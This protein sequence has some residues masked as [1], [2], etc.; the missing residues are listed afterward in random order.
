MNY[1]NC[2]LRYSSRQRAYVL[3]KYARPNLER[4]EAHAALLRERVYFISPSDTYVVKDD[5]PTSWFDE[6]Y[7]I[8]G[9]VWKWGWNMPGSFGSQVDFSRGG[10][11]R[12]AMIAGIN[13]W[14][15]PIQRACWN[16]AWKS[17]PGR[18]FFGKCGASQVKRYCDDKMFPSFLELDD[19][20]NKDC[21]CFLD[22]WSAH[23]G[24]RADFKGLNN[25]QVAQWIQTE[26]AEGKPDALQAFNL[27]DAQNHSQWEGKRKELFLFIKEWDLQNRELQQLATDYGINLTYLAPFW[28]GTNPQEYIWAEVKRLYK[29]DT[30]NDTWEVKLER[31]WQ[32]IDDVFVKKCISRSI[33]FTFTEV[34]RLKKKREVAEPVPHVQA[35]DPAAHSDSEE[36]DD[37]MENDAD[38]DL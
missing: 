6:A 34:E 31:A 2:E 25:E 36:D 4:L 9:E 11:R 3:R 32:K 37:F 28:S 35:A 22:N 23:T 1:V 17:K 29:M 30:S 16:Q 14:G 26:C 20:D 19:F 15:G 8:S 12:I 10:Y 27:L 33:K 38:F 13:S 7:L 5:C 21:I 18:R 24:Y